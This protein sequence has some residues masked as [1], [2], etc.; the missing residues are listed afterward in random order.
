MFI[1][2]PSAINSLIEKSMKTCPVKVVVFD[3]VCLFSRQYVV[4]TRSSHAKIRLR[5]L[6]KFQPSLRNV[7]KPY[8]RLKVTNVLNG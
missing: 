1:I 8:K 5:K 4:Q 2:N 3:L 7:T 6:I